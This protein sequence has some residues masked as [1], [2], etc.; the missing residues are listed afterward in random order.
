MIN[1]STHVVEVVED[2]QT[3]LRASPSIWLGTT[4]AGETP[5]V[6]NSEQGHDQKHLQCGPYQQPNYHLCYVF[7]IVTNETEQGHDHIRCPLHLRHYR[8]EQCTS[9]LLPSPVKLQR[10]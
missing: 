4:A 3:I 9:L 1:S 2:S 8:H 5:G 10:C 7:K 6:L